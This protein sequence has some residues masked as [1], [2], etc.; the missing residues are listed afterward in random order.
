MSYHAP[1]GLLSLPCRTTRRRD[2]SHSGRGDCHSRGYHQAAVI[3]S[4]VDPKNGIKNSLRPPGRPGRQENGFLHVIK[5]KSP[6]ARQSRTS[7]PTTSCR[8]PPC[9]TSN[10]EDDIKGVV[11]QC[12]LRGGGKGQRNLQQGEFGQAG[13]VLSSVHR[14]RQRL[15]G[16]CKVNLV[17]HPTLHLF[18]CTCKVALISDQND[19]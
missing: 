4:T 3:P 11:G 10:G 19:Q 15:D 2:C 14:F 8:D 17:G 13:Q 7:R 12:D 18:T 16:E 6:L 5:R 1:L 9:E